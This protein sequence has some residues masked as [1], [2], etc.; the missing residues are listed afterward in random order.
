L[1]VNQ[2]VIGSSPIGGATTLSATR[3]LLPSKK[4]LFFEHTQLFQK[5]PCLARLLLLV[6]LQILGLGKG[7]K[8]E[9]FAPDWRA[10]MYVTKKE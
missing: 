10:K 5:T 8:S 6:L 3:C 7:R 1:A 2:S 9:G 4:S